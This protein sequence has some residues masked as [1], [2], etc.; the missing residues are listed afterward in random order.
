M[1]RVKTLEVESERARRALE[2]EEQELKRLEKT[3]GKL[4]VEY[5]TAMVERQALQDETDL[6][7][8]R[9]LAADKLISGLSS[10]NERWRK[11]LATLH[12]DVEKITGNCLLAAG[13]LAYVGPFS[14]EFRSEMYGDWQSSIAERE[15]PL[16]KPFKLETHLSN[17]VEISAWNSEGLPPDELSV[18][19]GILTTK[20]SRF[21]FCI[22]PQQQALNWIKKREQKKNL[23]ILSFAD[24]DF[25][26]QVELAIKYGSPVLIQDVDEVDPILSNVLSKNVQSKSRRSSNYTVSG[27][28]QSSQSC[29]ST[30][31]AGRTFVILG[32]REVDY[33]SNFRI[34]MTTKVSNPIL[35]PAIYATAI[36][37]NYTVT[38]AV[39]NPQNNYATIIYRI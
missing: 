27:E 2:K 6:L 15:L 33:D 17:D 19:N 7:Q 39:S 38:T 13:F 3:I 1:D 9:L 5:E 37:I 23:K 21:P 20:A 4:N 18:Q 32:D 10:E 30:A 34:Y 28:R 22:D 31:V 35:D 14:Y 24:A 11:D 26:K 25:L 8:Q 16:S 12:D 29:V 36:V